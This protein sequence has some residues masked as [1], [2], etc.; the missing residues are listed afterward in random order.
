MIKRLLLLIP[1]TAA[2][3][4]TVPTGRATADVC[5][6][7]RVTALSATSITVFDREP[8]TYTLDSRTRY[9][10]LITQ[11]RWQTSTYIT[12][13]EF[14]FGAL[15]VGRLVAVH[16]RHEEPGVA[17]WVQIATDAR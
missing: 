8:V 10:R 14:Y 13:A 17:R 6:Y 11:W 12:P 3:V 9:T 16:M 7:G 4:G 15:D 1:M 5:A 2:I